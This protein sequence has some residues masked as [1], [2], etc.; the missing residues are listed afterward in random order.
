MNPMSLPNI[1]TFMQALEDEA[2]RRGLQ[3]VIAVCNKEGRPIAVHVMDD[4]FVASYD[5][6]VNKAFTAVSL[7]LIHILGFSRVELV[8][9][10][11]ILDTNIL[12]RGIQMV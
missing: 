9:L 12:V 2:A 1:K 3:L 4:A 5:I 10:K 11:E 7:S 8:V 6:A